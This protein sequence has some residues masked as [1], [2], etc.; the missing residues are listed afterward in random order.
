[1]AARLGGAKA[2]GKGKVRKVA[3]HEGCRRYRVR[4]SGCGLVEGLF[5][6]AQGVINKG[7]GFGSGLMV[8]KIQSSEPILNPKT[9]SP[10][11]PNHKP[12][13]PAGSEAFNKM[14][15]LMA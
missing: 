4:V 7:F 8:Y 3:T 1:M 6:A 2:E 14:L 15:G 10:V 9:L 12:K 13:S 5:E 11:N